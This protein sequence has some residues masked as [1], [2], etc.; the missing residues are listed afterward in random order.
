MFAE[1]CLAILLVSGSGPAIDG[2][3]PDPATGEDR[4]EFVVVAVPEGDNVTYALTDGEDRVS[5]PSLP[6]G[7]PVAVTG[8][9]GPASA[10]LDRQIHEVESF[11]S[12]SNGGEWVALTADNET[13]ANVSYPAS[14]EGELYREGRFVPP[15]R[16]DFAPTERANVSVR[17]ALLP[18][19]PEPIRQTIRAAEDRIL[20]AGYTFSDPALAEALI[21]ARDRN[22]T[23][24]VLLE[25]APVGGIERP[26]LRQLDRLR[27]AGVP[28]SVVGTDHA[29]YRY[30]HAKYAVVDDRAVVTSENWEP[31]STGGNG[32]RGWVATIDDALVA[33]DLARIFEADTGYVDTRNWSAARPATPV[34]GDLATADFPRRFGPRRTRADAVTVLAAPDNAE[35]TVCALLA[36]ATD[37]I[38]VQ[39]VSIDPAGEPFD[40]TLA[41]ARRGVRVRILLSGAWYVEQEN[42]ALAQ[43]LRNVSQREDLDLQVAL[44]EPRSRYDH[45]HTKGLLVDGEYALVGSLNW[46][47]TAMRENREVAVLIEDEAVANYFRRAFRADWRGAAWRLSWGTLLGGVVV[48]ASGLLIAAR[49]LDFEATGPRNC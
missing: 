38:R 46:N 42:R 25:G 40:R 41:A 15:G 39:Q 19:T 5:L 4:G 36:N 33:Q 3:Y 32:S 1:L 29:R 45:V 27:A 35:R 48:L 23:V 43:R 49:M 9:D 26:Q 18:D 34:E 24:Q 13:V 17:T 10:L 20:L 30:H 6:R 16:T 44:A 37:S 22:V 14:T 8:D 21:A 47:P 2:I 31:G 11:L 12:L 7:A 28:V